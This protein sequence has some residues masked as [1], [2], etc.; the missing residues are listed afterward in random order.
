MV[1]A[2]DTHLQTHDLTSHGTNI[3][4]RS[5]QEHLFVEHRLID[6]SDTGPVIVSRNT[7][8]VVDG[9][10]ERFGRLSWIVDFNR[11]VGQTGDEADGNRFL[12]CVDGV[13]RGHCHCGETI[14]TLVGRH[15]QVAV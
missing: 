15:L 4:G 3:R 11:C 9:G 8:I 2:I 13:G 10:A 1:G 14:G 6:R 7:V 12:N 5:V